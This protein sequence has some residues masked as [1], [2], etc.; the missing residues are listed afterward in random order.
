MSRPDWG[1]GII[2]LGDVANLHLE[3]YRKIG[4][5]VIGGAELDARKGI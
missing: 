5:N 2:G 4:L 3:A 1:I